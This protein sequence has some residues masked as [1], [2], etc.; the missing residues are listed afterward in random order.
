MCLLNEFGIRLCV[1]FPQIWLF[2]DFL[3]LSHAVI[4]AMKNFR[5]LGLCLAFLESCD[6]FLQSASFQSDIYAGRRQKRCVDFHPLTNQ[7]LTPFG[8]SALISPSKR[9]PP[10]P[11]LCRH[12]ST[13]HMSALGPIGPFSPFKSAYCSSGVVEKE[14]ASLTSLAEALSTK[15]SRM[16]LGFQV[17]LILVVK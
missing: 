3:F 17:I 10:H 5:L 13:L 12:S 1:A 14:M 7:R 2:S 16:M 9:H 4:G 8:I 6:A 11:P 15:F